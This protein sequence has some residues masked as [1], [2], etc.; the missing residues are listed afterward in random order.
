MCYMVIVMLLCTDR[1]TKGRLIRMQRMLSLLS[2]VLISVPVDGDGV[3][4]EEVVRAP[5]YRE[6]IVNF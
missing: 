2:L 3:F 6:V 4:A 5:H 1:R